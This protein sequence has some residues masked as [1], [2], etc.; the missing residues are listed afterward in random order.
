[1]GKE[2]LEE[3]LSLFTKDVEDLWDTEP[4]E[5]R[6]VIIIHRVLQK[7]FKRF[8][9]MIKERIKKYNHRIKLTKNL[10]ETDSRDLC[11]S[12]IISGNETVT[13]L[14]QSPKIK[15]YRRGNH[16]KIPSSSSLL[17]NS[18][19]DQNSSTSLLKPV[20]TISITQLTT[21][22]DVIICESDTNEVID[23]SVLEDNS[24]ISCNNKK[25][26]AS[27]LKRNL[28]VKP[29]KNILTVPQMFEAKFNN[30][31][32][33]RND[34]NI[35]RMGKTKKEVQK[36]TLFHDYDHIP[37]KTSKAPQYPHKTEPVRCKAEKLR[38]PGWSCKECKEYYEGFDLSEEELRE[39]MNMCSK[40]RNKFDPFNDTPNGFWDI[41]MGSSQDD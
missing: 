18:K 36:T 13:E 2:A 15:R 17:N 37:M 22:S 27:K 28:S 30:A 11:L 20:S 21:D 32:K 16:K 34:E 5:M 31:T 12:P 29:N 19:D 1:M 14:Q 35:N 40:H 26:K 7:E 3:W 38:L 6:K 4:K 8:D 41:D 25:Y 9:L 24:N 39:K 33:T 10:E 23:S